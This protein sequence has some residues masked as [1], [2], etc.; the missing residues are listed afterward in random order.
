MYAAFTQYGLANFLPYT[1]TLTYSAASQPGGGGGGWCY[2]DGYYDMPSQSIPPGSNM[3]FQII[4]ETDIFGTP[5]AG[6]WCTA[7]L[8]YDFTDVDGGQHR[9]RYLVGPDRNLYVYSQD[10]SDGNYVNST[11]TFYI[12]ETDWLQVNCVLTHPAEVTIDAAQDPKA[13]TS[14]LANLWPQGTNQQFTTTAGPTFP[15]GPWSRGSAVVVNDSSGPVTLTLGGGDTKEE[16]TSIGLELSWSTSL[17]ILGLVNQQV[18]ASITGGK[19]WTTSATDSQSYSVDIDPNHQGWLEWA[20]SS[21]QIT[22]DFTFTWTPPSGGVTPAGITY[23]INNATVTQPGRNNDPAVPAVTWRPQVEPNPTSAQRKAIY[24]G[25]TV[26]PAG[27]SPSPSLT[28]GN[29]SVNI[30]AATDPDGAAQAMQLWPNATNTNFSATS[31]PI[32]TSTQP[33]VLSSA[34]QVPP[35]YPAQSTSYA[36]SQTNSSSWS[37]GGSVGA[38]TTLSAL[39]F[40]NASVSVT[41]TAS[42]RWTTSQTNTQTIAIEVEP[43]YESWITGSQGQATFTGDYT[44]TAQGTDYTVRNVTVTFPAAADAGPLTAFTYFVVSQKLD[45]AVAATL[46]RPGR[47]SPP[48]RPD[49]AVGSRRSVLGPVPAAGTGALM[50]LPDR[51][52]RGR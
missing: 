13:A 43:G 12:T 50:V 33:E 8:H 24:G 19:D 15:T 34:Y 7:E 6:N 28:G 45:S 32:Y 1:M 29:P 10:L 26:I 20:V 44:F 21:A 52:V 35:G 17:D 4:T 3:V 38:E 31:N 27:P 48:H 5:V 14:V 39:G 16:T 11:A 51:P 23:H 22:G 41:F 2:A 49:T 40:A 37:I 47:C 30:D 36:V 42:H 25:V 18:S 46:T 9:C